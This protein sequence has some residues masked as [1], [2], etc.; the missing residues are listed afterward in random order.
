FRAA[1]E[2]GSVIHSRTVVIATSGLTTKEFVAPLSEKLE[3]AL[4]KMQYAPLVV[5]HAHASSTLTPFPDAFGVLL[6]KRAPYNSLG[7][8]FNSVLFPHMAPAGQHLYTICLGGV[9][10]GDILDL[11]DEAIS[12]VVI[13]EGKDLL[14][15]NLS[16][17]LITRWPRAIPQYGLEHG[18]LLEEMANAESSYQGLYFCGADR[19]G[20]GVP[21]RIK[22]AKSIASAILKSLTKNDLIESPVVNQ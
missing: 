7:I 2:D 3:N 14:G 17:D 19:G 11:S 21:D 15:V 20:V 16:V 22:E 8:M 9:G 1:C 4:A 6:P 12:E 13:G 5:V 18:C 10:N